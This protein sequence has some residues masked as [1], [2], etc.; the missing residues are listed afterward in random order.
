MFLLNLYT[1]IVKKR[2]K[3]TIF[4]DIGKFSGKKMR[5]FFIFLPIYA[6]VLYELPMERRADGIYIADPVLEK[7][8]D[9]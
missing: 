9:L 4:A 6:S 1:I 2:C 5:I 3:D 7:W 8:L